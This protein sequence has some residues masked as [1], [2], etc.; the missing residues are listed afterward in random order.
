MQSN[1]LSRPSQYYVKRKI[2]RRLNASNRSYHRKKL[3]MLDIAVD[4]YIQKLP[5]GN[6]MLR[7]KPDA[8]MSPNRFE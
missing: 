7:Q 6:R 2:R 1:N 8:G 3:E 4:L 5:K